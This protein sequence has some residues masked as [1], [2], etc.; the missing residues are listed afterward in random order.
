MTN[1]DLALRLL[2]IA[3]KHDGLHM[4]PDFM[5]L[6]AVQSMVDE[7]IAKVPIIEVHPDQQMTVMGVIPNEI[8][9]G[10]QLSMNAEK[11]MHDTDSPHRSWCEMSQPTPPEGFRACICTCVDVEPDGFSDDSDGYARSDPEQQ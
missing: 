10:Y 9:I 1:H 4:G 6:D 5:P 3:I 2:D 8:S 7:F 11:A